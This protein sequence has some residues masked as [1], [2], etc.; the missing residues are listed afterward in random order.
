MTIIENSDYLSKQIITYLGNKRSLLS[1]IENEIIK[2][3][4][5]LSKEKVVSLDLFS[6]SGIVARLFKS[7]SSLVIANDLENYS[8]TINQCYLSNKSDFDVQKFNVYKEWLTNELHKPDKITGIISKYYAPIDD[9][10]IKEGERCFYT[11]YNAQRIDKIRTLIDQVDEKYKR[12]F[13]APLIYQASVHTNTSGVFKG[14]YKDSDTG[15]GKFGG[16]GEN[17]LSRIL[18]PINVLKPIFSNYES[19]FDVYKTDANF[20]VQKLKNIDITYIDP[21]YNQHPYGSNYFM[22]NIIND[23]EIPTKIST[24]SGIPIDW[25]R[26]QYNKKSHAYESLEQLIYSLDSKFVILS[27]NSEG[28]ISFNQVRDLL[29]KFGRVSFRQIKYNTFRGS[30]N[31]KNRSIYTK[32]FLFTLKKY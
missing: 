13:L 19:E 18:K 6:G 24:V 9:D 27:Y 29:K 15:K 5:E 3:K 16:N 23:Y 30:R 12:F 17:A 25:N 31:L 7:H 4:K 14:F 26:S 22:L 8:M 28:I 32:E 10:N 20:L 2:I 21:P 11:S 1:Q